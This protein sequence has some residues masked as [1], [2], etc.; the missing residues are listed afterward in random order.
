M[1]Y[2]VFKFGGS[3]IHNAEHIKNFY[4]IINEHRNQNLIII[5]SA[6]NKTTNNLE[7]LH[8]YFLTHKAELAQKQLQK[9]KDFHFSIIK[10][11]FPSI[12]NTCTTKVEN[13]FFQLE[14]LI[15]STPSNPDKDYST[16]VSYGELISTTILN[17]YLK[18][19][20]INNTWLDARKLI[21]TNG[22]YRNANVNW[23]ITP[24][25][26]QKALKNQPQIIIT[27][28]FIASNEK[29]E[30][31]TLGREGSD[32]TAAIFGYV[33]DSNE[34]TVWKDVNGIYN[35]D[36]HKY[37]DATKINKLSYHETIELSYYGAQV[38]HPKTIK[39]LQNKNI[40]L[41]VKSFYNPQDTGTI[42]TAQNQEPLPPI[43]IAKE[44]QTL[45]TIYPLDFSFI[46]EEHIEI[47][48]SLLNCYHIKTSLLQHSAIS[49]SI[50]FNDNP[51]Y[52]KEL[53]TEL[54]SR[55]KVLYNKGLTLITIRHYTEKLLERITSGK[56][57]FIEQ[58]TRKTARFV[59][60]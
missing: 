54:K 49:F 34:V 25:K 58:K 60:K 35:K 13:L 17:E 23:Q 24:N 30:T 21:I 27:Q 4:S 19:N 56:E 46:G 57:I 2:K 9:I 37:R 18:T 5:A 29:G 8:Q 10:D 47:L 6:M 33:L 44:N 15:L 26:I 20:G 11:L 53:L 48:F 59:L 40:P 52:F 31:T 36:P 42:I 41:Y 3:S 14:Q 51:Y 16:I 43:F 45:L 32:Y 1:K 39:P 50:V 38:I 12:D 22:T 55:F 28:G 7:L